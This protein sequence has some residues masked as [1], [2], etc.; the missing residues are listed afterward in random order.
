MATDVPMPKLGLTMEE[1]RSSSGWS[2][3]ARRVD[4]DQP[5]MLIETD[6]TETEVGAPGRRPPAPDRPSR[7]DVRLRRARRPI[8]ADGRD[9]RPAAAAPSAAAS[10]RQP[11]PAPPTPP[12]LRRSG[13]DSRGPVV[14]APAG[15]AQRAAGRRRARRRAATPCAAPDPAVGSSRRT[16]SRRRPPA[17]TAAPI[18]VGSVATVAARNLA[19][20]LGVDLAQVPVDPI[21]RRVTRE[22]SP[23]TCARCSVQ[24]SRASDTRRGVD[25]DAAAAG[26]DRDDPADRHARHDRQ[27]DAR[28]AAGDGAA[29][30]DDG[31]RHDGGARRPRRAASRRPV[32]RPS[33]TDYVVA[34]TARGA[35]RSTRASTRRSPRPAS[36]CCPTSTSASPSPSTTA[37]WCP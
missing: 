1:A 13:A 30:V 12:P 34:A 2:P 14:R 28:L 17:R 8:L 19:D 25:I 20:L 27:A 18:H 11:T 5:I 21:E 24:P 15:V 22:A 35:R 10:R 6:K 33:I 3:T 37:C 9:S 4:S 23:C 31:R 36:R 29:D 16:C 32:P 26:A 7:P